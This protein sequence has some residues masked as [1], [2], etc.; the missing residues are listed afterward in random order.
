MGKCKKIKE[1][2]CNKKYDLKKKV[3]GVKSDVKPKDFCVCTCNPEECRID[4][5]S[6]EL[7]I[8]DKKGNPVKG[9][10]SCPEIKT[11]GKCKG[12][13]K[14]GEP[15]GGEKLKNVCKFSCGKC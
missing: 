4:D 14:E 9:K 10:R 12:K 13:V 6:T 15:R 1:K 11:D 7:R 3:D 5:T 8:V 2:N